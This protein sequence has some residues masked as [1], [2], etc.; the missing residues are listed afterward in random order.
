[1]NEV[2]VIGNFGYNTNQLGGQNVKTRDVYRLI[3][4][5]H[6][7]LVDY[8][9]TEDFQ[10]QTLSIFVMFRKLMSCKKLVYLPAHKNLKIIFPIIYLL[11]LI[12]K[13]KINYFVV[14]GW[15][16]EFLSC[17]PLHRNMLSKINGIHVETQRLKNELE[18]YYYFKNVDIFPN[19]RFFDIDNRYTHREIRDRL[20]LVFVSRVEKSKGL[21]TLLE[22]AKIIEKSE[23]S[24]RISIDFYGQIKDS[25]FDENLSNINFY[26]YQG[27]LNP[28]EVIP[29]LKKYDILIFPS[30]YDGEGC[31]G[32][33]VEAMAAGL[34]IIASNWKYNS[35]F[36]DNGKNGMLCETYNANSY[37]NAIKLFFETNN[38]LDKMSQK[39]IEL[40]HFYSDKNARNMINK[41][42][43]NN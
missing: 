39:A 22:L 16:R 13:F 14:G 1:M 20:K 23:L 26:R 12:F 10:I 18:E 24:Q 19:F 17:K 5:Q 36:V 32:I 15:L 37:F 35:E 38:L 8:Y 6:N 30:H 25:F 11:S 31:P 28:S 2:L 34:P 43:I 7:G 42:L 9:D 29:T 27:V 33:L 21:D 4:E 3:L 41:I 40:S